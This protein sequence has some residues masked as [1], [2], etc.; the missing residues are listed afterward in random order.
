MKI[1]G[2]RVAESTGADPLREERKVEKKK[3]R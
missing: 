3:G 1:A 2:R